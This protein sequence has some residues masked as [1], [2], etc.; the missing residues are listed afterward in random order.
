METEKLQIVMGEGQKEITIREGKAPDQ[1]PVLKPVAI[2][3]SGTIVSVVEFLRRRMDQSDQINQKRCH[4]IVNREQ[5][6]ILLTIHENDPYLKGTVKGKLDFHPKF[7]EF[8]INS[9][10]NWEPNTLG[11][12]FKMNRA[13]FSDKSKNMELVSLLKGFIAKVNST[14]EKQKSDNGSFADNYSGIVTSNLP[15]TFSV[16]MPIFKG[17]SAEI[18]ELELYASVD[19]RDVK[20]QLFSPGAS[21]LVEEIRDSAIDAQLTEIRH[22]CSDIAI[23]EE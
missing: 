5:I 12:F 9:G 20:L 14:I 21:Q 8:G 6:T 13:F 23:I 16:N 2:A 3:I 1:L 18:I 4:I 19:G 17:F 11:Q 7:V 10:K 15:G 22:I